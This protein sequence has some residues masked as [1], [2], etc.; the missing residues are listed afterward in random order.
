LRD[1]TVEG[2]GLLYDMHWPFRQPDTARPARTSVLHARLAAQGACF[3][4][5]AGWERANWFAPEGTDP[6]YEYSYGRQNWFDHSAA[7][8]AAVREAVGLFD[9][10]SFAKFLL[11][12]RDA[13]RVLNHVS[14]NDVAVAP[15]RVVYTQWLNARG[16]IEADLTVTRLADDKYL[17][18]TAAAGQT[19][20]FAWLRGHI[21]DDAYAVL[22]D[23][24][25]GYAVLGVMGPNSRALLGALGPDDLSNDAFPYM[26]AREI[27]I[28][29]ATALALRTT[30]VGELGWE[31]YLQTEFAAPVYD[32]LVEAGAD[33]GLRHAGYHAL[34][35]LRIERGFRHWGHDITDED[36]PLEAGLGFAVA[37]QKPDFI[38]REALLRQR[39]GPLKK[40][41]VQF[42]LED[43]EPLLY[44]NEPVWRDGAIVGYIASGMYGHTLGRA[45]GLG[46]LSDEGGVSDD[47]VRSGTYEIEI[48]CERFPARASLAPLYDPKGERVRM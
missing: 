39:E 17:I 31:L 18:V 35:S 48:A 3:G 41:L 29:Y 5:T 44:H 21:P 38:G 11:Q 10:S 36:T 26:T 34:N 12:G 22:T 46:Y 9:Q 45:I 28:G 8:H 37:L 30:Y 40:R 25:S 42:A 32:L 2:L 43:P 23:M 27:E 20:D 47:F 13:E 7:E 14:A 33:H 16:G 1:R 4:E 6:A 19:R 24:T 15:G